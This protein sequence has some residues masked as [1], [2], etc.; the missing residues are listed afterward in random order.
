VIQLLVDRVKNAWHRDLVA[1]PAI[2]GWA[3]NLYRAGERYPQT[4]ADYF[5]APSAPSRMLADSLRQHQRDEER[6]TTM[7]AHA[8]RSLGQPVVD[9]PEADVFNV[10]IRHHTV[11]SFTI[12]A[13]DD[14]EVRRHKVAHFL[15]HAHTLERRV[16]RSLEYHL[17]ACTGAG[18][19]RVESIVEAVLRDERE[20]VRYTAEAARDLLTRREAEDTFALHAAAERRANLEFSARQVRAFASRFADHAPA[21]H[22]RFY[23]LCGV[24]MEQ[25]A[26]RA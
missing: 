6:H 15:V 2:H 10:A 19:I 1:D 22:R 13:T 5:P 12:A 16:A 11:S 23:R 7:Y 3:L 18:A 24:L 21:S 17:D 4:V 14:A 26:A 9:L 25:A 8:I 20:H